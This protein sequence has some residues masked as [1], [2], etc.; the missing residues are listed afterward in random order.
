MKKFGSGIRNKHPGSATP[1]GTIHTIRGKTVTYN[2][3]LMAKAFY[4][5]EYSPYKEWSGI[6]EKDTNQS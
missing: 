4:D 3:E 2:G 5:Y 6:L 1:L